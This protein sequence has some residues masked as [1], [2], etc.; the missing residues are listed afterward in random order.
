MEK[1]NSEDLSS[2]KVG[3]KVE[4][5]KHSNTFAWYVTQRPFP[6][7]SRIQE[8]SL[9]PHFH[10]ALCIRLLSFEDQQCPNW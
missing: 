1:S 2:K 5:V 9:L 7:R 10:S 4:A 6:R 3:E 8:K